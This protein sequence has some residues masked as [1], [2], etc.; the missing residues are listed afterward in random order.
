MAP[1]PVRNLVVSPNV[2][3]SVVPASG[4]WR[5]LTAVIASISA[6]GLSL[7]MT[8]P[9][10]S[11][12]LKHQGYDSALIGL[13]AAM[14]ALGIL[15]GSPLMPRLVRRLGARRALLGALV[16]ST[17]SILV[18]PWITHY[19]L[20]LVLRFTMG[21]A[22]G[23]LFTVSET[24]V[25]QLAEEHSRGRLVG[26][27]ITV[28]SI[29]FGCGPLLIGLTGSTGALPFLLACAILAIAA[30]PLV[31]VGG[32]TV[33]LSDTPATFG[34][35]GFMRLAPTLAA[36]VGMFAAIDGSTMALL[37]LFGLR[38]GYPEATAAAMIT[39]LIAGNIALQVPLGWLA[40]RMDR[41]RLLLLCGAGVLTGA[42]LL[43]AAAPWSLLLW[44]VLVL[45][46]MAA[47]GVYTLAMIIVGQRFQGAEL[48]TANA[49]FGVLWGSGSLLGPFVAGVLMRFSDPGG[50]PLTWALLATGFLALFGYRQ[51]PKR[52]VR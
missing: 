31:A 7:G 16:V 20:W 42:L 41:E 9:L 33:A 35:L 50:L 15:L 8:L 45:L 21:A 29:C 19:P 11:L 32:E 34:V 6:V 13:A 3:V 25:N 18:M 44:P 24:W 22:D 23:L 4:Q 43:L 47:G 40:D 12:V 17:V 51:V 2:Q 10:I 14:P 30:L 1:V 38:S 36:G 39:V 26:V 37:P 5:A 27:Y 49:A 48:V 52:A 46:G 28:L